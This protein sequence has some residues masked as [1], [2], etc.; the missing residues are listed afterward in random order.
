M[1]LIGDFINKC[2]KMVTDHAIRSFEKR[3]NPEVPSMSET[4]IRKMLEA[5]K[6]AYAQ[7]KAKQP[8]SDAKPSVSNINSLLSDFP[9]DDLHVGRR[10]VQA[11]ITESDEI[12]VNIR[13]IDGSI[14]SIT[15]KATTIAQIIID[16]NTKAAELAKEAESMPVSNAVDVGDGDLGGGDPRPVISNVVDADEL[17]EASRRRS[18]IT[19]GPVSRRP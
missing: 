19:G 5:M 9:D 8:I 7:K 11:N 3:M 18:N 15:I 13:M 6:M 16:R 10:V 14:G 4:N 2:G 12:L 1:S 17:L